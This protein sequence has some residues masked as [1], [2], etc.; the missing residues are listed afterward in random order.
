VFVS[1][2]DIHKEKNLWTLWIRPM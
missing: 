1:I 2:K